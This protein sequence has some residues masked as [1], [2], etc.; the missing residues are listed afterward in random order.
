MVAF[1]HRNVSI[2][3][4]RAP[5]MASTRS[6]ENEVDDVLVHADH[7]ESDVVVKVAAT[8]F[9]HSLHDGISELVLQFLVGSA[10]SDTTLPS[11]PAHAVHHSRNDS[12][13]STLDA[14]RAGR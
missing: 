8:E 6:G 12:M 11:R 10:V 1:A 9:R 5:A 7:D 14:L 13:G 3:A 4:G 2:A